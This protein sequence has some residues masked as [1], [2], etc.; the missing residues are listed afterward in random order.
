MADTQLIKLPSKLKKVNVQKIEEGTELVPMFEEK[1][2]KI[3]KNTA[4]S[5]LKSIIEKQANAGIQSWR[6][7]LGSTGEEQAAPRLLIL[8]IHDAP[9]D[10]WFLTVG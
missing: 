8:P 3:P 1:S 4:F 5:E 6:H 2:M 7:T 9:R 10:H